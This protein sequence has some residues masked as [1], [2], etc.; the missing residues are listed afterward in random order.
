MKKRGIFIFVL[1]LG[2]MQIQSCKKIRENNK[3]NPHELLSADTYNELVV[4][5]QSFEGQ[6]PSDAVLQNLKSF[7]EARLNKPAGIT[8]NKTSINPDR[9]A[10]YSISDVQKIEQKHRNSYS[11]NKKAAIYFLFVDGEYS[12]NA[13]GN[14]VLGV[15]YGASSMV[16]FNNSISQ[17]SGGFGQPSKDGLETTVCMHEIGHLLGLV[18]NGSEMTVNHADPSNPQHCDNKNCLMYW[19]AETNDMVKNFLGT[20][21]VLDDNCIKDLQKNGGK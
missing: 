19:Q 11:E 5:V 18:N 15:A 17:N 21:P 14:I 4:E 2:L 13:N 1:A 16:I 20:L 3:I 8:F 9:S 12:E 10:K 6:E 7:L